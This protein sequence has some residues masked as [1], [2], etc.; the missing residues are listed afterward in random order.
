[1]IK[2]KKFLSGLSIRC[3]MTRVNGTVGI[4]SIKLIE[5]LIKRFGLQMQ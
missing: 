3:G 2:L 4:C 5:A 1:M